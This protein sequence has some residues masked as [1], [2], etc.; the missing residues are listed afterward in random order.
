MKRIHWISRNA[1]EIISC[2]F[3]LLMCFAVAAGV[4]ARFLQIS[5]VWTDEL[6]RY[7]FI[8]A[9]FLGSVVALKHRKHIAIDFMVN[10]LPASNRRIY[11]LLIH[12]IMLLL[13][14]ALVRYGFV[15]TV[16]TWDV[17]T[18]SLGVPTGLV[19]LSVPL[20][21][22]LM[23]IYLLI[24]IW[25]LLRGKEIQLQSDAGETGTGGTV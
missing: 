21:G 14:L 3:F 23:T 9:V 17:P 1:E 19:Y 20:S 10:L 12:F 4:M 18:T 15:L 6:A 13:C 5:L 7:S 22:A 25:N 8:W 24:D 16:Q 2:L 11:F